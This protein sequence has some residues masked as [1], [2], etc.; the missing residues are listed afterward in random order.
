MEIE[1]WNDL[2]GLPADPPKK[3]SLCLDC[4]RPTVVCWC[5]ALPEVPVMTESRIV[6]LQHPA[7]EKRC[8]RTVPMLQRGLAINKCLIFKGKK[9]PEYK[10]KELFEILY[11]PNSVLLYPS[12]DSIDL[13]RFPKVSEVKVPYNIVL[14]DG[15]WPQA[16]GIFN[17]THALHTIKQAKLVHTQTSRYVIRTQPTDGCLSTLETAVE[18]LSILENKDYQELLL[19]PL[20]AL[21]DFQLDHGAVVHD[22]KELRIKSSTYPKQIGRRLNRFLKDLNHGN[23]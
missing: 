10:Y 14:I 13:N 5:S 4:G 23:T 11:S 3:R 1:V 18:A 19:R 7:E 9:F 2:V 22:S 16:K 8:L 17:N 6:I 20:K 21:C 12:K 15:T